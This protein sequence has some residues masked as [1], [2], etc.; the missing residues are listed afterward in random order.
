M[1]KKLITVVKYRK[2]LPPINL[3][4]PQWGGHVRSRD[5]LNILYLHLQKIHD[6]QNRHG[7]GYQT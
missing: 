3:H 4:D 7:A 2:E 5:K 6:H 1:A